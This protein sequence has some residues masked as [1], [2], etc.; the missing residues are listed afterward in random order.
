MAFSVC[1][2]RIAGPQQTAIRYIWNQHQKTIF[3]ETLS[4]S[5][6]YAAP[7]FAKKQPNLEKINC[8]NGLP[9]SVWFYT[10]DILF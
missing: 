8:E 2:C 4:N 1:R 6:I 9:Y 5:M 10:E 7:M 3:L